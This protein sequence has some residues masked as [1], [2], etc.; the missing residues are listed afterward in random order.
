MAATGR[1]GGLGVC[2]ITFLCR[3]PCQFPFT[4]N[5]R[6]LIQTHAVTWWQT[7]S[8]FCFYHICVLCSVFSCLDHVYWVMCCCIMA[9]VYWW[10]LMNTH[11]STPLPYC[12][13]EYMLQFTCRSCLSH[14][15]YFNE[16]CILFNFLHCRPHPPLYMTGM[17][18]QRELRAVRHLV[19]H[20]ELAHAFGNPP[21]VTW[22]LEQPP[23]GM[24]PLVVRRT[25]GMR[26]QRLTEVCI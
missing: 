13:W 5:I 14:S 23:Q 1:E 16:C 17:K 7:I 25:D 2:L 12:W 21:R 6:S 18:L 10:I 11:N 22:H 19:L 24:V 9:F 26:H 20:L 8:T 15:V 4:K 3:W